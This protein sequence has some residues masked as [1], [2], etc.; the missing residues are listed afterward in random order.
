[1]AAI[2]RGEPKD[3]LVALI[4]DPRDLAIAHRERWYRI[5]VRSAP[6]IVRNE[7][8]R[9][10]A[11]YQTK[12]FGEDAFQIKWYGEVTGISVVR[13]RELFGE[14]GSDP[15]GDD[16]YY[17]I[18]FSEL[19]P[20]SRP[21]MSRRHRRIL[22][23]P[24]TMSRL[25]W[26][27]ELNDVFLESPLEEAMWE[28]LKFEGISAERQYLVQAGD[29][30]FYLDF[31]IFSKAR[32]VDLECDGDTYHTEREDVKRDKRRDN[33]LQNNGWAVYRYATD[34]IVR[35]LQGC[36]SQI[37]DAINSH[38]GVQD[39]REGFRYLGLGSGGQTR[40]FE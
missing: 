12:T 30:R 7:E 39:D 4:N 24:T 10:L 25:E 27:R 23:I 8:V 33:L 21:I 11:F 34:D 2:K 14:V 3:A 15:K 36:M 19:R 6:P 32:H 28:A 18:A 29:K 20:F 1:M 22:F 37:K 13:R 38:G 26:A 40:L 31:A 17:R 5:P 9:Y 16:L 35:D